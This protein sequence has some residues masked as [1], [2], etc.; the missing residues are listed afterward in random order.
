MII[1]NLT[2]GVDIENLTITGTTLQGGI[3]LYSQPDATVNTQ[4]AYSVKFPP[5]VQNIAAIAIGAGGGGGGISSGASAAAGGGGGGALSYSNSISINETETLT[6]Q[7]PNQSGSG[8]TSG[9]NGS[10][11][12]AATLSRG[13]TVLL[14]AAGGTGSLGRT[15]TSP[16]AGGAGGLA[17][18]GVGAVR[19]SGGT[20]GAGEASTDTGGGGGGAAGYSSNG[21][22]GGN[23]GGAGAA[24][25]GGAG[26]GGASYTGTVIG[27][28]GGGTLWYGSGS[29]GAG[30]TNSATQLVRNGK[31]GSSLGGSE[32]IF[33]SPV[34]A[35]G[36]QNMN[37]LPGGGGAGAPSGL[38]IGRDG[39][40]GA[41]GA[42][43]I[44]WGENLNFGDSATTSN[45]IISV[46][47]S[48]TSN[49]SS[50]TVPDV[51]LGDTIVLIDY[52]ENTIGTPSAVTPSGFT[53]KLDSFSLTRRLTTYVKQV[54]SD[55]ETG[56]VLTCA[57]GTA[58]NAKIVIVMKGTMG[59]S[60]SPF[61]DDTVGSGAIGVNTAGSPGLTIDG[62]DT[63]T[64]G[65]PAAFLFFNS[66]GTIDPSTDM[67]FT[68]I[69]SY[70]M[71]TIPG[72][73][74]NT[75]VKVALYPTSV[76]TNYTTT[77]STS[78]LGTNT[79]YSWYSCFF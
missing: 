49:T 42:I 55:A 12:L 79:Y 29:G 40:R 37:G 6:V 47:S 10:N 59:A 35:A 69:G 8:N 22:T 33:S 54:F 24:G 3:V 36:A 70:N 38:T 27:G 45:N 67:G 51:Q 19:Y 57:N 52:S 62:G 76:G 20:G 23:T 18:A 41:G 11:G 64:T 66:T 2:I 32:V 61:G 60:Y 1:S 77:S 30:G 15:G 16:G 56:N 28:S 78:N 65:I 39:M 71:V 75:Y 46:R 17:S 7:V 25:S 74:Q 31:L 48:S 9:T 58:L 21:A 53:Q 72:P 63:F 50:I 34:V 68:A 73:T 4:T 26:G 14:S 5:G 13:A 44:L 43:R